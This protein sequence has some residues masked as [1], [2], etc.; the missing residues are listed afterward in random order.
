M[1]TKMVTNSYD[2]TFVFDYTTISTC[3]F[4]MHED[5]CADMAADIISTDLGIPITLFDSAQDIVIELLDEDV[6]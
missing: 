2:V 1:T 6:L 3:V 5:A 4:A